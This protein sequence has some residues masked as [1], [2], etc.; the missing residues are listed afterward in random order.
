[1]LFWLILA[2]MFGWFARDT[3]PALAHHGGL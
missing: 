2:G 1:M 3:A